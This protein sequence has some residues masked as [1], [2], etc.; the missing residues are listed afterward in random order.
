MK[1][2]WIGKEGCI[3]WWLKYFVKK[4]SATDW[5]TGFK[6]RMVLLPTLL[7]A[8]FML[9]SSALKLAK[10]FFA[11]FD[12]DDHRKTYVSNVSKYTSKSSRWTFSI[13]LL[14]ACMHVV[15]LS[16]ASLA[17]STNRGVQCLSLH[18]CI[19]QTTSSR[20]SHHD[21]KGGQPEVEL[22]TG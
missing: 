11:S 22:F 3:L 20:H 9:W 8:F 1:G 17:Y 15:S 10:S 14:L 6:A 13:I 12:A 19:Q 7:L 5:P 18:V 21:S 4:S 16:G 2:P